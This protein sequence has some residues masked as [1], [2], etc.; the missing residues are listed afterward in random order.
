MQTYIPQTLITSPQTWGPFN[1][2]ELTGQSS[3][4]DLTEHEPEQEGILCC[5]IH[6]GWVQTNMAGQQ[7][8]L[9]CSLN[10]YTST[11]LELESHVL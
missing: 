5:S 8:G 3:E 6:P 1:T 4:P 2:P 9:L 11:M 7:G 10:T